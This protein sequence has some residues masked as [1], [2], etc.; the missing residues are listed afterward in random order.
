[1][2]IIEEKNSINE[3]SQSDSQ[4]ERI[5]IDHVYSSKN[6][7][8]VED[9]IKSKDKMYLGVNSCHV[10][11]ELVKNLRDILMDQDLIKNKKKAAFLNI[12]APKEAEMSIIMIMDR[13]ET[14][15]KTISD[16]MSFLTNELCQSRKNNKETQRALKQKSKQIDE[17]QNDSSIALQKLEF[18]AEQC[19]FLKKERNIETELRKNY[20]EKDLQLKDKEL[21]LLR[22]E[23]VQART[24]SRKERWSGPRQ[25]NHE[26]FKRLGGEKVQ[27]MDVKGSIKD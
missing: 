9:V 27:S 24:G 19:E 11:S 7:I 1:M 3:G 13:I 16:K 8:R 2:E 6:F 12:Q 26:Q 20:V 17:L 14:E 25:Y 21:T 10:L 18:Y 5:N 22:Q 4:E 23:I 15:T